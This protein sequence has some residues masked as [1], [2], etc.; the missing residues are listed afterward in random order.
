MKTLTKVLMVCVIAILMVNCKKDENK[1][2]ACFDFVSESIDNGD[3]A[4]VGEKITFEN[5]S[6]NAVSYSWD[7]GDGESSTSTNPKHT[8]DEA[9]TYSVTLS[10]TNG[11]G[12]TTLSKDLDVLPSLSGDWEGTMMLETSIFSFYLDI[13]QT[14]T[15]LEGYFMFDD[16][17]GYAEFTSGSEVDDDEVTIKFT[18]YSDINMNFKFEGDVNEDYDEMSGDYTFSSPGYQT[19]IDTWEASKTSSKS[20]GSSEGLQKAGKENLLQNFIKAFK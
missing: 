10:A 2:V 8:Y 20:T 5:C 4:R 12:T 15:E 13:E 16:G 17:S 6:Q 3:D 1:P 14:G 9:G 7:F 18:I 19:H 11:D